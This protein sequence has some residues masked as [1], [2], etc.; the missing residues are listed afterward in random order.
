MSVLVADLVVRAWRKL[1]STRRRAHAEGSVSTRMSRGSAAMVS[2]QWIAAEVE[3]P[4][5]GH[6]SIN[7]RIGATQGSAGV[8]RP[9]AVIAPS[10][11]HGSRRHRRDDE[12]EEACRQADRRHVGGPT[13]RASCCSRA[14]ANGRAPASRSRSSSTTIPGAD[15]NRR[16][17]PGADDR[18][19]DPDCTTRCIHERV[20]A[21]DCGSLT[22]VRIKT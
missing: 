21:V 17:T 15:G 19:G 5:P 16:A 9:P 1:P 22:N 12:S 18:K 4:R 7:N 6:N 11:R 10:R 14:C 3:R 13:A 20:G 2:C 8:V